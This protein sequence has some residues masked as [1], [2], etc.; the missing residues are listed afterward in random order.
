MIAKD[1]DMPLLIVT[2]RGTLLQLPRRTLHD[3][4]L[5]AFSTAM[6]P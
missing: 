2:I 4:H 6:M 3:A 1:P 5:Y